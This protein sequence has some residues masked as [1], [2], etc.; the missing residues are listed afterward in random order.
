[1]GIEITPTLYDGIAPNPIVSWNPESGQHP[2]RNPAFSDM[3]E[4]LYQMFLNKHD[5]DYSNAFSD[6]MFKRWGFGDGTGDPN[7]IALRN[8]EHGLFSQE[9]WNS[10]NPIKQLAVPLGVPMYTGAKAAVQS[11][12]FLNPLVQ[13]GYE[14][15]NGPG[16]YKDVNLLNA[17]PASWQEL[18][19]GLRPLWGRN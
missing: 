12:P 13:F 3:S 19:W 14:A 16:S 15:F 11:M 4:G 18:M 6:A 10:G 17:T 8:A 9:L 1:M 5:G 7:N 2:D